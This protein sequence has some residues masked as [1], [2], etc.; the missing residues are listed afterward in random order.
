MFQKDKMSAEVY[1]SGFEFWS[2]IDRVFQLIVGI[3]VLAVGVW[4]LLNP[5]LLPN[6]TVLP[7][8]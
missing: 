4:L 7:T 1:G 6:D 8:F 3:V 2:R 5:A